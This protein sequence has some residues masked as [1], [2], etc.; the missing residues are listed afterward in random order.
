MESLVMKLTKFW[1]S[2]SRLDISLSM[3]GF[4]IADLVICLA[5]SV[6]W[7]GAGGLADYGIVVQ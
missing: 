4:L 6:K 3:V 7:M 2:A 1:T 5:W